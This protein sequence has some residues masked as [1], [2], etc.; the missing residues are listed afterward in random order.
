VREL[1]TK[2]RPAIQGQESKE[3]LARLWS[4]KEF[5]RNKTAWPKFFNSM[6]FTLFFKNL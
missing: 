4:N 1:F 2:N 5:Q 3:D 6:S